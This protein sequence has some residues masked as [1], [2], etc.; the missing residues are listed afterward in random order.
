LLGNTG[1]KSGDGKM[2]KIT[3]AEKTVRLVDLKPYERNPRR[4]TK[5]AFAELKASLE[6]NGY[7]QRIIVT[8][9]FRV[10]GGHQRIRALQEL[11]YKEITVLVPSRELTEDEYRRLLVQDNLPFGNWDFDLLSSDFDIKD[12][13][14]WGFPAD[15]L[16]KPPVF[17]V[18]ESNESNSQDDKTTCPECGHVF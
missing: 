14:D 5:D 1:K 8:P 12:L 10:I 7:H 18:P 13:L 16:P 3:W 4:I 6:Q 17:D 11:G 9:D 2:T 15:L